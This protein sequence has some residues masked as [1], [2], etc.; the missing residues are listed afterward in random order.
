MMHSE[1]L[2]RSP[3]PASEA[4]LLLRAR[5]LHGRRIQELS[6]ALGW[7]LPARPKAAKG[8]VGQLVEAA[9]GSDVDAGDRPDFVGL[10]IECK[11]LPMKRLQGDTWAPAESTFVCSL[12]LQDAAREQWNG[13]RLQRRLRAVLWVAVQSAQSAPLPLRTIIE[14]RL[15]RPTD[16]QWRG[17]RAD[18]E[19]LMGAVGAGRGHSLGAHEGALLQIRPKAATSR[20]RAVGPTADGAGP[21]LP[22][23]F[24]LR[25]AFVA[26]AFA[27]A[28]A[29]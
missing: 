1:P 19:D 3:L 24:Y 16:A 17:L 13:S 29:A 18:W 7:P 26:Q 23:G 22:L 21:M 8:Y 25:P 4:E 2:A 6:A 12:S 27:G 5:H 14:A 15:W 10:G 9:L 11:T 28:A 20:V